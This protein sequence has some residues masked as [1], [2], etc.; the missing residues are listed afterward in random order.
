[1]LWIEEQADEEK[2]N[3]FSHSLSA[4]NLLSRLLI[5]RGMENPE[6]AKLF[7]DP[8]LAHLRDPFDLKGLKEAVVRITRALEEQEQILLIGDY[9]VDGITSTVIVKQNLSRLGNDP[10]YVIPKRKDEG[11]GLTSEVLSRGLSLGEINL[12]IALDCGTNSCEE[13]EELREK[14][15][16]LI[17]VD[18]HQTKGDFE[19]EDIAR[20]VNML[21]KDI[22]LRK[23]HSRNSRKAIVDLF[24]WDVEQD[25]LLNFYQSIL[26][27]R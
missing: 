11:Y 26:V 9:D 27:C 10:H 13:A 2:I 16:D 22:N 5:H 8:K 20:A 18:H 1:M 7:L 14:G 25:K 23:K 19:P 15:I 6:E 21:Y 4:S 12:V 17:I 24:N 3:L